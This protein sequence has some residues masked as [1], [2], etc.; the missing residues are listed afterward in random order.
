MKL[1]N[2]TSARLSNQQLTGTQFQNSTEVVQWLG[3]VQAQD[4]AA[5]KWAIALRTKEAT[6]GDVEKAFNDGL[7]L[8]THVMRPTWHFVLPADI[9]WML[10]L[11]APRVNTLLAHYDRKL[12]LTA[13]V[14]STCHRVIGNALQG[15]T[16]RTRAE[17]ADRLEESGILARGQRLGHIVAHAELDGLI[18]SG[19][20]RGKQFTYALLSE[21][22]PKAK[23]IDREASLAKLAHTYFTSHGPAQLKDFAWWSG[24]SVKDARLGLELAKS[25]LKEE[26]I[27]QKS[28]WFSLDTKI[29]QSKISK[30][31]LLSIYDEYTIA[32]KDRS[33]LGDGRYFEKLIAMG[34]ALTGVIILEGQIAGTWK[35]VI[36]K[37]G[38]VITLNPLRKFSS[39]EVKT[40]EHT[41]DRYSRFLDL[42][43]MVEYSK[44]D[45]S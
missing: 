2:I 28:Y 18:C 29:L 7:I 22:A 42:K 1:T 5:A 32:Y 24:L 26:I 43:C 31:F 8:R 19:P 11:T 37:D 38:I 44:Y 3:A 15:N 9:R 21:R 34:N 40:L 10:E 25:K 17:L 41:T 35:R 45:I 12:E 20:R 23:K 4:Y 27:E 33:A 13:G 14:L 36:Q 30:A 6:D 39:G 16:Y